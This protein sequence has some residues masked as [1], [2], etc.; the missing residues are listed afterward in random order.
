MSTSTGAKS[1]VGAQ[2]GPV[3]TYLL[4]HRH[5]PAGCRV[6]FAAWK[7]FDSPLR[8]KT[9]LGSCRNG[10]HALW[11]TV[12]AVDAQAALRRLP[13]YV[14]ARTEAVEVTNTPIP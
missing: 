13:P 5:R 6:A 8:A 3:T 1:G 14:A 2:D 10:H 12:D 4:C 11:W 9:A 7:G